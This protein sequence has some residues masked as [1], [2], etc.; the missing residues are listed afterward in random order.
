[1]LSRFFP[2]LAFGWMYARTRSILASTIFHA[3]CNLIMAVLS[4]SLLS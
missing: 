3:A 1:M 4:A 2:G